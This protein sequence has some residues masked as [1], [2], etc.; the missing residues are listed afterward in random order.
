MPAVTPEPIARA[1][2]PVLLE[3]RRLAGETAI[4]MAL[5][6]VF[7][8]AEAARSGN[9]IPVNRAFDHQRKTSP[10]RRHVS[11]V[12]YLLYAGAKVARHPGALR[13]LWPL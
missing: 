1:L 3:Y 9:L 12:P 11:L 4:F 5:E 10:L 7:G 8:A 6:G 13:E 2:V